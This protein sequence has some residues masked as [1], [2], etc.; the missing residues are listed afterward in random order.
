MAK[1]V[2]LPA[3]R[4]RPWGQYAGYRVLV[5]DGRFVRDHIDIDFVLGGN[6]YRYPDFIPKDEIW[7]DDAVARRELVVTMVHEIAEAELMRQGKPYEEAHEIANVYERRARALAIAARA[8]RA[9]AAKER[10]SA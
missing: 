9:A 6:G 4:R 1:V 10:K 8:Q 7:I 3:S 2:S 5:V